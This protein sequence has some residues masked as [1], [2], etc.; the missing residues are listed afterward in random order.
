MLG[1]RR[2]GCYENRP[3]APG[4]SLLGRAQVPQVPVPSQVQ[5]SGHR[6]VLGRMALA[7]VL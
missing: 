2:S 7:S 3:P 1:M 6:P 5:H 4:S